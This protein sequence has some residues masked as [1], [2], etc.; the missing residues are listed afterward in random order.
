MATS[1]TVNLILNFIARLN[2][3]WRAIIDAITVNID[4]CVILLMTRTAKL[5]ISYFTV[6]IQRIQPYFMS[7]IIRN[8][9]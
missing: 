1:V 6:Q 3:I 2:S 5:R 4:F 8:F 7:V 9:I